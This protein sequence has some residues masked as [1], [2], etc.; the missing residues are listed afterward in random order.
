[1]SM[2]DQCEFAISKSQKKSIL[3]SS[4]AYFTGQSDDRWND[5]IIIIIIIIPIPFEILI[6][7]WLILSTTVQTTIR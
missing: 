6:N 3:C 1:M 5:K 4:R 2:N 7:L